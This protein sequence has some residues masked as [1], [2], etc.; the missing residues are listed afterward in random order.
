MEKR[1]KGFIYASIGAFAMFSLW[2]ALVRLVDVNSIGPL[3]S[4]VGLSGFNGYFHELTGVNMSLYTVTDWLGLVPIAVALGFAVMGL[5]QWIKRKSILK[6]DRSILALGGFYLAAI[7][8]YVAFELVPV[9]YRPVLINGYLEVSY[10]SSTTLLTL[11]VM[12]TAMMQLGRRIKNTSLKYT[13][14]LL[15]SVFTAFTVIGRILSG[16]HWISDIIGGVILSA[17]LIFLYSAFE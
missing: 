14:N 17:G 8:F 6:V 4:V 7:A 12:L 15:I 11:C 1:K 13:V 5:F 10:P 3:D 9:N 16:V 2:T